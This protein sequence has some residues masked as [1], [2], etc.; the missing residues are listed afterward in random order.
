MS[1]KQNNVVGIPVRV[2][3]RV[4]PGWVVMMQE[5]DGIPTGH[6]A[7]TD[8]VHILHGNAIGPDALLI[9]RLRKELE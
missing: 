3:R 7:A 9:E 8:G 5:R 1:E 2:D 6:I 4:P